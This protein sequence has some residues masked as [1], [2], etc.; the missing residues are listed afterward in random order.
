MATGHISKN[1]NINN[2][3]KDP[4]NLGLSDLSRIS[5]RSLSSCIVKVKDNPHPTIFVLNLRMIL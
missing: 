1:S 5:I 2:Q 4:I 3:Y